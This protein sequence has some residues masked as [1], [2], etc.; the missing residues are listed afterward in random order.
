MLHPEEAPVPLR[1][2]LIGAGA[3]G[4]RY[5][6]KLASRP[7]AVLAAVVDR[8]IERARDTAPKDAI[9]S[10]EIAP[11]LAAVDAAIVVVPARAHAAMARPLLEAGIAVLMEK[12]F[13]TTLEEADLLVELA[14]RHGALL[15]AAHLE[16]FNP[17]A[18]AVRDLVRRPRFVEANRLGP[19]PGRGTDVDVVL[20]LMIHDIDLTLEFVDSPLTRVSAR[21]VPVISNEVDIANAR[22]EF[23]DGC[24]ADLTASRVSLK[25]ERKMRIFQETSYLSLDFAE[26]SLQ[27]VRRRPPAEPGGWPEVEAEAPDITRRDSLESQIA[28][29]L[30]AVRSGGPPAV[31]AQAGRRALGVALQVI[32]EID[33]WR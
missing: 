25:R 1:V 9:A 19:F 28:A 2:G 26:Q 17:A 18:Q 8:E 11:L 23:S 21:G 16:R 27:V 4:R 31:D 3:W 22:L 30:S 10:A 32:A 15:Q 6:E 14:A 24:V 12:P 5:A 29:F 7:D 33:R 13:A 20:D